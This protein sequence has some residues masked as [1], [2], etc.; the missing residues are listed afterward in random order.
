MEMRRFSFKRTA[1][2]SHRYA[3]VTSVPGLTAWAPAISGCNRKISAGGYPYRCG[4]KCCSVVFKQLVIRPFWADFDLRARPPVYKTAAP[5]MAVRV[6]SRCI[7]SRRHVKT[8]PSTSTLVRVRPRCSQNRCLGSMWGRLSNTV[9]AS[10]FER[11][12]ATR[13][14]CGCLRAS[15]RGQ[16]NQHTRV[17]SVPIERGGSPKHP[18]RG[19]ASLA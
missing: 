7:S 12:V 10:T 6:Q 1:R 3:A 14:K 2:T 5:P 16:P 17:Q 15:A 8:S 11:F 18:S 9:T 13:T 4:T 19:Q